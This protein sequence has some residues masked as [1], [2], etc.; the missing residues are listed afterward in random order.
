VQLRQ[1]ET[2]KQQK[3]VQL[4]QLTAR[5]QQ[6]YVQFAVIRNTLLVIAIAASDWCDRDP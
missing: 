5:K 3:C 6:T 2:S 4:S 1:L